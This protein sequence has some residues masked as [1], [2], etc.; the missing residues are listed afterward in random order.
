MPHAKP[1]PTFADIRDK[2]HLCRFWGNVAIRSKGECW[3]WT[4]YLDGKGYG[5]F[6]IGRRMLIASRTAYAIA[7]DSVPQSLC[8]MHKCD[9]PPCCNPLH[10]ELGTH[11]QNIQDCV[12]R[13][14]ANRRSGSHNSMST[15]SQDQADY[16]RFLH[17][18]FGMTSVMLGFM[19]GLSQSSMSRVLRG[20]SYRAT[21]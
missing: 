11:Q 1:Y 17:E 9:N 18:T 19:F 7:N 2:G 13:G 8:V 14:R 12:A 4:G 5:I 16:A 20:K 21:A 6:K 15:L 10:L 3:P